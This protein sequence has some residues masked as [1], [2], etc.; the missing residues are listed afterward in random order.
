MSENEQEQYVDENGEL[1][2][3]PMPEAEP[4]QDDD[5]AEES[6]AEAAAEVDRSKESAEQESAYRALD[7]KADNYFKAVVAIAKP[8]KLPLV[9][10][11][12]C[13]DAYAGVR[14]TKP[15]NDKAAAMLG[16]IGATESGSP[17]LDDP[18]AEL[19]ERCN[20]FGW[21]KL[22]AHVPGNTERLCKKCNG[23]G[24]MD[25]SATSG[26]LVAPTP[27]PVNGPAEPM[28]GVPEDDPSVV[29][30]RSRGFTVIPPLAI[31]TQE[32]A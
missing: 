31:G 7:K 18:D 1:Q 30:L 13:A 22:P 24:W 12:L 29:D 11:E 5:D 16:I 20:G 8:A 19:C 23:A 3:G 4:E 25:R 15:Q 6:A 26:A 21:T 9:P 27:E 28:P 17:L 14:W 32:G 2:D 10:C